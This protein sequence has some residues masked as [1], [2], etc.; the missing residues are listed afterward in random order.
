MYDNEEQFDDMPLI[1]TLTDEEGTSY[2]FEVIDEMEYNGEFY[3][4]CT[5]Y[6]DDPKQA[7]GSDEAL[8]IFRMGEEDEDGLATYDIVDDD[9]EYY[10]V[11]K[12]FED[13]YNSYFFSDDEEESH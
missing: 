2:Q 1:L 4:A 13:R 9:D 3:T 10:E 12:I 7:L 8:I 5:E 11:G 6:F